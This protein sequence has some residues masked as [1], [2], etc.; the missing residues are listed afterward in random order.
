MP[1]LHL[2]AGPNGS[3][4]STYANDVLRP[5][6]RLEFVNVDVIAHQQWPGDEEAH[7]YDASRLAAERRRE[8]MTSRT[9]FITETVFSLRAR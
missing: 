2:L 9:S 6:T 4:K 8:L 1:V 3:G 7:A 5:E